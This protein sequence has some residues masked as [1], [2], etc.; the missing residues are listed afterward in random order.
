MRLILVRHG[1]ANPVDIDPEKGLSEAGRA[2]IARLLAIIG[3]LQ[4]SVDEIWHSDKARATQTAQLLAR[5]LKAKNGLR[6]K[7]NLGPNDDVALLG[8]DIMTESKDLMIV[9]H[10]PFLSNLLSYLLSGD[11]HKC[12]LAFPTAGMAHLD[13]DGRRWCLSW[14]INPE[15]GSAEFGAQFQSYH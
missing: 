6:L 14:F 7:R 2:E 12:A 5:E 10:L 11:Q 3:P 9:G 8:D 4:L 13:Y 1:Q 15:F